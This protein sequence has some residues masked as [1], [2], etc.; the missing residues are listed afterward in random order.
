MPRCVHQPPCPPA[1]RT[2]RLA[3]TVIAAHPE[4]GWS[5]LCNGVIVFEDSGA[6]V[7]GQLIPPRRA[8]TRPPSASSGARQAA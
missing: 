8:A 5:L 1:T 6:I 2:D 4:Q 7:C 3:A